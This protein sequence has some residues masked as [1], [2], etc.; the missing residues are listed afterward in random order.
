MNGTRL[1]CCQDN[2]SD[3]KPAIATAQWKESSKNRRSW[4]KETL[5]WIKAKKE[6]GRIS[7]EMVSH[8]PET[9][10]SRSKERLL[11]PIEYA[12]SID[13][14]HFFS[15]APLYIY[16]CVC[17]RFYRRRPPL[18]HLSS[19]VF[20]FPSVWCVNRAIG[21]HGLNKWSEGGA[22]IKM[23][24]S[25]KT[26]FHSAPDDCRKVEWKDEGRPIARSVCLIKNQKVKQMGGR[27]QKLDQ[28]TRAEWTTK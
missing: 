25:K 16:V 27:N 4:R 12:S 13:S 21:N 28:N 20:L 18:F 7:R 9:K 19:S 14:W 5:C 10:R 17:V 22:T 11:R 23:N 2:V 3:A 15:S 6:N 24:E 8:I 26:Q 1:N